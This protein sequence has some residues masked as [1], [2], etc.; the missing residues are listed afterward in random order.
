MTGQAPSQ[1]CLVLYQSEE[2]ELPAVEQSDGRR[3]ELKRR[4]GFR[5]VGGGDIVWWS[6]AGDGRRMRSQHFGRPSFTALHGRRLAPCTPRQDTKDCWPWV[7][8]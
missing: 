7:E 3:G 8:R 4:G 2:A 5:G 6:V 1:A